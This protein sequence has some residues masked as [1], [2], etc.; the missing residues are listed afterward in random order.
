[1]EEGIFRGLFT[2]ILQNKYKLI[3]EANINDYDSEIVSGSEVQV[4]NGGKIVTSET[5]K[6]Y[7][8]EGE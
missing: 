7:V 1:M 4:I 3:K 5:G 2:S 6:Y 8:V